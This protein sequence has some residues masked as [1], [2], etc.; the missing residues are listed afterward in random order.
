MAYT[1]SISPDRAYIVLTID[2]PITRNAALAWNLEAHAVGRKEGIR[3]FL[4]DVT[5][6][7]N[8]DSA[9]DDYQ[10]AYTDMRSTPGID[11]DACVAVITSAEDHS[12]DFFQTVARNAGLNVTFF[13]DRTAAEKFLH[14]SLTG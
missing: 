1:I 13:T 14:N 5:R 12:H 6:A 9:L 2:G 10:F 4:V 11:R 7:R 8:I 3:F